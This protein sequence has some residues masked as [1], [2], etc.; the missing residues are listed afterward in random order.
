[1]QERAQNPRL[2]RIKVYFR[3]LNIHWKVCSEIRFH[4]PVIRIEASFKEDGE[5]EKANQRG[6]KGGVF[7]VFTVVPCCSCE[8]GTM[9]ERLQEH[10]MCM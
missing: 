4:F 8:I 9:A 3:T 6:T 2:M 5:R 1:M 10:Y 7:F